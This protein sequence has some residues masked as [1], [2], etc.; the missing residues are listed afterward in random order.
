LAGQIPSTRFVELPGVDQFAIRGGQHAILD[1]VE[2]FLAFAMWGTPSPFWQR[3]FLL[4]FQL[5]LCDGRAAL[6]VWQLFRNWVGHELALAKGS[7]S[8]SNAPRS[9]DGLR[10]RFQHKGTLAWGETAAEL[11][12]LTPN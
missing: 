3:C 2:D 5:E 7:V 4:F 6:G 12:L 1:E 10:H 8:L 11:Q 9:G